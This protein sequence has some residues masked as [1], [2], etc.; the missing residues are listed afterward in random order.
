MIAFWANISEGKSSK[1]SSIMYKIIYK[2]HLDGSYHS[3]WL[4]HIKK[5]L[6]NSGHPNYWREQELLSPKAFMKNVVSLA[7]KNQYLQEWENEL[8]RNRRCITY[9]IFKDQLILEPYLRELNFVDRLAFCKFR[10]GNHKLPVAKSRLTVGGG[11]VDV[12]CKLCGSGDVCD[13]FHTLFICNFF[14]DHRQ[15]YLKKN[16]YSKPS[17]LKMYTLFNSKGKQRLNLVKFIRYIMSHF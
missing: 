1:L 10:T 17:T 4:M 12:L 9:R 8:Y 16:H 11:N 5:L 3:P 13:E 14:T 6:C 7:F 2:L 15:K